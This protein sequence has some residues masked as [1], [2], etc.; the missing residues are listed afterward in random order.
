MN[1]LCF[2]QD[3][4][5]K[6]K[7]FQWTILSCQSRSLYLIFVYIYLFL[8]DCTSPSL[9]NNNSSGSH[10]NNNNQAPV[11]PS[12]RRYRTAF[13]RDQLARLEKEFYKENYVSRPRRCELAAQLNLPESTIK[14]GLN[15]SQIFLPFMKNIKIS[16]HHFLH[17]YAFFHTKKH[18]IWFLSGKMCHPHPE[19]K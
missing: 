12:I 19:Q 8:T 17:N 10:N 7:K 4:G 11:D 18:I 2:I 15:V 9:D 3:Y 5:Q 16:V 14:V 6:V 1:Q 13:T